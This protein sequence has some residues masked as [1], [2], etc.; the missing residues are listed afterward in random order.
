MN[1]GH[2][3][4]LPFPRCRLR[5]PSHAARSCTSG[6]CP[7]D[8]RVIMARPGRVRGRRVSNSASRSP[9]TATPRRT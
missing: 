8:G 2:L 5:P 7:A 6:S 9:S 1:S 4:C 3:R